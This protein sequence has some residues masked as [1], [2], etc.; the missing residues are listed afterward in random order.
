MTNF[1]VVD[2]TGAGAGWNVTVRARRAVQERGVPGLLPEGE[3]RRR[4]RR[5]CDR[6]RNAPADSLNLFS[7]GAALSGQ[8]GS[9][10][11]APT[12][13]CAAG[14]PIDS[15]AAE[16]IAIAAKGAGMGTWLTGGFTPASLQLSTPASLKLLPNEEVYRVNVLWTLSTGP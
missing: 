1:G 12:L 16:T 10:G 9:T 3:M 7:T 2:A 11:T 13:Q 5:L 6:G 8:N 14:C 15:A 4:S